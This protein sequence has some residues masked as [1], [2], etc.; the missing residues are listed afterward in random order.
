MHEDEASQPVSQLV[1]QCF[2]TH[3]LTQ[4]IHGAV[5]NK[6]FYAVEPTHQMIRRNKTYHME[7]YLQ[8][9]DAAFAKTG[10]VSTVQRESRP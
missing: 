7:V 5:D 10:I 2:D 1:L 3:T 6:T 9:V 8:T 4:P